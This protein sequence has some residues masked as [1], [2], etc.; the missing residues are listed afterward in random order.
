MDVI[1]YPWWSVATMV[2]I[3]HYDSMVVFVCLH[4][5]IPSYHQ[6]ADLS[7]SI[8]L[9]KCLPGTLCLEWVFKIK[10]VLSVILQAIQGALRFQL[11]HFTYDDCE[12][13]CTLLWHHHQI[14]SLT[15][16]LLFRVRSRN[17]GM[18]CMSFLYFYGS[19]CSIHGSVFCMRQDLDYRGS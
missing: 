11:T 5:T 6:Y 17:N 16:L 10:S 2:Q 7:E 9:L 19:D 3:I 15:H 1:T 12:N 4:I 14:G 18:R 8:E 13:T